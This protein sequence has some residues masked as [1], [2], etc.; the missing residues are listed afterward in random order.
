M[1]S[2]RRLAA[3]L[4]ADVAGYS[5]LMGEDEEGTLAE[6]KAIRR[7]L[8]DPLQA[9]DARVTAIAAEPLCFG[10]LAV[11]RRAVG[12]ELSASSIALAS[13]RSG[14]SK[15]SVNQP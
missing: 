10:D 1:A 12:E 3:I 2:T 8:S 6:L 5:R 7:E 13:R 9:G 15:P 11:G 4:A 14:V